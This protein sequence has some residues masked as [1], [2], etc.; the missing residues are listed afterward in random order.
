MMPAKICPPPY[1][2]GTERTTFNDA[3]KRL[4]KPCSA[5]ADEV[6]WRDQDRGKQTGSAGAASGCGERLGVANA[7]RHHQPE[8]RAFVLERG[9]AVRQGYRLPAHGTAHHPCDTRTDWPLSPRMLRVIEGVGQPTWR[10]LDQRIDGLS[11]EIEALARSRDQ[12]MFCA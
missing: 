1:S 2:K 12:A 5:P 9:I 6:C 3:E 11:G 8:F 4:P 7:T 10:W